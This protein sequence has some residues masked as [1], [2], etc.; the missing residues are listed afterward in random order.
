[1]NAAKDMYKV[2]AKTSTIDLMK[3]RSRKI[4]QLEK[5]KAIDGYWARKDIDRLAHMIHQIDAVIEARALQE[6]LF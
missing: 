6:P 1:M 5:L 2:Y 3:N 4:A